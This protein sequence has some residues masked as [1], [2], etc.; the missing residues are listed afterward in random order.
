MIP[1][2]LRWLWLWY[3]ILLAS[4]PV[5]AGVKTQG[6]VLELALLEDNAALKGKDSGQ[7]GL[8]GSLYRRAVLGPNNL[9]PKE[10]GERDRERR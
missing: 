2:S 3:S 1:G 8:W 4:L 5:F 10:R 6:L 7:V 9:D